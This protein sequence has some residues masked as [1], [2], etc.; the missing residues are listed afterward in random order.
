MREGPDDALQQHHRRAAEKLISTGIGKFLIHSLRS[1]NNSIN[2]KESV[3]I[4]QQLKLLS[5]Y[6]SPA[7][8]ISMQVRQV[9]GSLDRLNFLFEELNLK[10]HNIKLDNVKLCVFFLSNHSS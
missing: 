7:R 5:I 8:Q 3:H 9:T 6:S 4:G 2:E 1:S 10:K